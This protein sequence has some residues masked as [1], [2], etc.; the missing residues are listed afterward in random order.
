MIMSTIKIVLCMLI[1]AALSTPAESNEAKPVKIITFDDWLKN[2]DKQLTE[3]PENASSWNNKGFVLAIQGKY[4]EAIQAYDAAISIDPEFVEAW[5]N[6]G[7]ALQALARYDEAIEAYDE[8]LILNPEHPY[9]WNSKGDTLF[10]L[11]KYDE[12]LECFNNSIEFF[13]NVSAL[14]VHREITCT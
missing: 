9:A 2:A 3:G 4:D 12:A 10:K 1:V 7:R 13:D 8:A 14:R 11:G 6:K 5:Y